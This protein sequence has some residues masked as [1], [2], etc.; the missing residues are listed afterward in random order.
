MTV[1][2]ILMELVDVQ[3][4]TGTSLECQMA[5]KIFEMI[6]GHPYFAE[7]PELCG[8]YEKNDVFGRNV[9][10][11]L[12]KGRSQKTI[13][14]M[15]H[16]DAVEIESYGVLKPYA[17]NPKQLKAKMI[18][19]GIADEEINKDL[20]SDDWAF[21]RGIADMKAGVAI[22]MHTLFCN[23]NS[24]VNILFVAVPDEENMS[25][26]A[27][28]SVDLYEELKE[29]FGL[30]YILCIISEP[31]FRSVEAK[32]DYE[33]IEGATGKILPVILAKGV[34][35][36]SAQILRGLNSG[37]IISEIIRNVELSTHMI[38]EDMGV[39]T[40]PPT[41]L[42]LK[43]LKT[44]YDVSVP[45]YSAACLNFLFLQSKKPSVI[46]DEIKK[47]C[48]ES[49]D[50]VVGKYNESFDFM[51]DKGFIRSEEKLN[52]KSEVL[53]FSE[54]DDQLKEKNGYMD[55]KKALQEEIKEKI[56]THEMNFQD[57][58]IYYMRNI[59]DF[60]NKKNPVV[61]I[62]I[63]PPYYPAVSLKGLDMDISSC[64]DGISDH[65]KEKYGMGVKEVPYLSGMADISY[66]FSADPKDE[67][68]F[69]NN[70]V[71][72]VDIYD[73]PVEKIGKLNI[74]SLFL[75]PSSKDVHKFGERVYMPDVKDRIPEMFNKII[76]NIGKN[77]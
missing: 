55:F 37:F 47:I 2:E 41:V 62:G 59:L 63:A 51:N 30:N 49:I 61:L 15:G 70:L 54:L 50:Y 58:C 26:G 74:P 31:G 57:S 13:I 44:T 14:L 56:S 76:D 27:I 69:L 42:M 10:W 39:L 32:G 8:T 75:G 35:A 43:D 45:E 71:L 64:F 29:K 28:M 66:M 67:R 36:H 33:L 53:F 65:M 77:N 73:V 5:D 7:H 23:E 21:G 17:L 11:A 72:P 48:E 60:S 38:S 52:L 1:E 19:A 25:S 20:N 40:Q 3:S 12:R 46:I 68:D 18:E 34:L 22:N 6:K 4:D 9:V 16:Y 24:D